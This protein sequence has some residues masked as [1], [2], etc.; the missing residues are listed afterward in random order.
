MSSVITQFTEDQLEQTILGLFERQEYDIV[1][2][3]NLCQ[4]NRDILIEK[5][6]RT[7]LL[8]CILKNV[9][10][11]QNSKSHQSNSADSCYAALRKE[12]GVM[13]PICQ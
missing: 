6:F 1:L 8:G 3:S 11:N 13:L 7:F 12:S 10:E 4:N 5:N 2:R 9:N